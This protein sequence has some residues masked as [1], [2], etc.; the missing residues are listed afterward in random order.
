[1]PKEFTEDLQKLF[2]GFL[3]SDKDKE[4]EN[5]LIEFDCEM[6]ITK[7]NKKEIQF[8]RYS[9]FFEYLKNKE[10]E[11]ILLCDSRDIYFQSNLIFFPNI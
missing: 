6:L 1:M 11:N 3:I 2:L 10:F 7:I 8:K 9:I 5:K 4:L